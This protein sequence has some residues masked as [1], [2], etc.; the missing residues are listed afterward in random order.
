MIC[1]KNIHRK[2]LKLTKKDD[3]FGNQNTVKLRIIINKWDFLFS[4]IYIIIVKKDKG[5]I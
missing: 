3:F 5:F 1:L 4:N 2:L